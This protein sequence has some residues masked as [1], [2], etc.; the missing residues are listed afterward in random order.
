MTKGI[1]KYTPIDSLCRPLGKEDIEL[2]TGTCNAKGFSILLYK[3][4]RTDVKRLNEVFGLN[5]KNSYHYDA[6]DTLSCTIS[7]KSDGEW[8]D[9]SDVGTE[10]RAEKEKGSHSD[11]FKRAAFKWGIGIE[12]YQAPFIWIQWEMKENNFGGKKSYT[13]LGFFPSD[14]TIDQYEVESG[15]PRLVIKHAKKG[16]IFSNIPQVKKENNKPQPK[17][18]QAPVL[19]PFTEKNLEGAKQYILDRVN[20]KSATDILSELKEYVKN[21]Y[22]FSPEMETKITNHIKN[23]QAPM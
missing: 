2:R 16:I 22:S 3:T 12:L 5:W 11:A 21:K 9:R 15:K 17:D 20:Q 14:L 1:K 4:A 8:I 18:I 7:I 6:K 10:S 19:V 23:L 13:P